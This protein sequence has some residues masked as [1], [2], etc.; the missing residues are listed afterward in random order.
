ML[1][2]KHECPESRFGGEVLQDATY[3]EN[4]DKMLFHALPPLARGCVNQCDNGCMHHLGCRAACEICR[5]SSAHAGRRN[6][7]T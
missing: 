5:Q 6:H 2:A 3:P 1:A 7:S 4:V